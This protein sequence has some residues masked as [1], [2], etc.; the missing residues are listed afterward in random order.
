MN[1]FVAGIH[2]VGKTYLC[3][4]VSKDQTFTHAS[5]SRLIKEQLSLPD[6]SNDKKVA[7]IDGNQRALIAAIKRYSD[8][9]RPLLLDGHFL[10]RD[11]VGVLTKIPEDVFAALAFGGVIL[12]EKD[13]EVIRQQLESRDGVCADFESVR[14][15]LVAERE[16][17]VAVCKSLGLSLEIM[18]EPTVEE[19]AATVA[20]IFE[21]SGLR[22]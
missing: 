10:L 4:Q 7:D 21:S 3:D 17:A 22:K 15:Q 8:A 16:Q 2:G 11:S 9:K 20:K 5:A 14:A 6:W 1:V 19:F 18:V 12:L 13:P